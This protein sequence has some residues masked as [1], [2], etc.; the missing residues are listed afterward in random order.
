MNTEALEKIGIT[1]DYSPSGARGIEDTIDSLHCKS[2]RIRKAMGILRQLL[3]NQQQMDL[4][5]LEEYQDLNDQLRI[6]SIY[7]AE[8]IHTRNMLWK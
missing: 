5:M 3:S 2:T 6:C 8:F 4:K 7:K 1:V